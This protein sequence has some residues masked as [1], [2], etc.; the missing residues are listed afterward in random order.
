MKRYLT[1]LIF[2]LTFSG[3]LCLA[4]T[5]QPEIV[6]DW[7][8]STL[9]QP[10]QEY[11]QVNSQ[12]YARFRIL[13]PQAQSVDVSL[14]L[15]GRG[16][17]TLTKAADGAWV[18]ATA[19][20]LDEGFHYYHLTIDGGTFNDP[21]TLNFYGSTRWESGIEIPAHDRDFYALKDVPH[22]RVQQVLFPSKS[23]ST[24]RRAFVYTPPGYDRDLSRRYPVLYLQHGWGE[25]E[26]AWSNQGHANLIMDNLIAEGR[27]KPFLIVMTYG[28][29]NDVRIGGL[30]NFK[31]EPFQT[32]LVD[33]LIPYIDANFHT[34]SDQ[35]N[36]A[37]AGLSMGGMETRWITLA[38]PDKFSHIGLF[39]GGSISMDDVNNTPGFKDK[40]KL[41]F[42]S[43]GSRELGGSPGGGRGP[44][45]GDPRESADAL[46]KAGINSIFY[47]SP[48]TAHEFLSWRRSLYEFA[49]LL[50]QD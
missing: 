41:V 7:K 37:M 36:R 11:P 18:G 9:N 32:V 23:T 43:Y 40:V 13:A 21:G 38:N 28:M 33:E 16:G 47:V 30:A 42:V 2:L 34:L 1:T 24:S 12:G 4:Q 3:S 31:I 14:G 50:F 25:D 27:I 15:G 10:G 35:P 44:F 48:N 20:P 29:T 19:G 5:S 46:K 6:D 22:G 17:T 45:G 8:P 49:P 26:T 39:S